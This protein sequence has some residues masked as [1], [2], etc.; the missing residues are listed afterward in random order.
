MP[1]QV[2]QHALHVTRFQHNLIVLGVI[3]GRERLGTRAFV[4]R[5]LE[6]RCGRQ[7]KAGGE[8]F[9]VGKFLRRDTRHSARVDATAQVRAH[10]HVGLYLPLHRLSE[11]SI[12]LLN[13]L[14][15][16][17]AL[18]LDELIVPPALH[19]KRLRPTHVQSDRRCAREQLHAVEQ[20][21]VAEHV[22][23]REVFAKCRMIDT[24]RRGGML[25]NRLDL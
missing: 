17:D 15:F 12:Q 8:T 20:R 11:E 1:D 3:G 7:I 19:I 16:A 22:L 10:F 13:V 9:H 14:T 25:Q 21:A 6:P 18:L 23:E 24:Y 5:Q 4:E 2:W